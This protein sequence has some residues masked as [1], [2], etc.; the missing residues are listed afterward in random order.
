[1]QPKW[2]E[3]LVIFNKTLTRLQEAIA[4]YNKNPSDFVKESVIQRFE[5]T[6]EAA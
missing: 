6:H 5:F 2:L 4:E 1:M 3:R